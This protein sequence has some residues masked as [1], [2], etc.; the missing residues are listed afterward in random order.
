M[1]AVARHAGLLPIKTV[2]QPGPGESGFPWLVVS[3][4]LAAGGIL[5]LLLS[6][7]LGSI[8]RVQINH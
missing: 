8:F 7:S 3:P 5:L 6:A 4:I 1:S 2:G